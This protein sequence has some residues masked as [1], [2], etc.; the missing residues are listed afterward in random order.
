MIR[1]MTGYGEAERDTPAGRLRAEIKTVNHRFFSANLRVPSAL[2]RFDPLIREWLRALFPRGHVNC[3]LRLERPGVDG[4]VG[5]AL[6]LNEP[7]ARAYVAALEEL[8]QRLGLPGEIDLRMVARFGDLITVAD[9]EALEI[10]VDDVR[11]VTQAAARAAIVF[12]EDEGRRLRTDLEER[13][14][15]MTSAI[16]T[17]A[18]RAP[19]RLLVERDR[20]R[21][22]VAELAA[23]VPLDEERL[24]R[25]VAHLAERWDVSEELVRLRAHI[26][27][28]RE[29]LHAG[30]EEPVGKRLG[31]LIQEM[32]R[33]AN[34]IGSKANDAPIE[35]EVVRIKNEIERL[36]EQVENVE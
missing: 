10:S 28:F 31:F 18:E 36:R 15:A 22:V 26:D 4:Q 35:H 5:P 16:E 34:T 12:R 8:Q 21:R 11:E 9:S 30:A 19:A 27:L 32:H 6:Q 2:D 7:R 24:A 20:I 33:E 1:S 13:L 14:Q 25:E 29:L 3:S 23:E 17:I